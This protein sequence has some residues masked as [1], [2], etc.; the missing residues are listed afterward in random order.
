MALA[1]RDN[2][3]LK[4]KPMAV[5]G[6]SMLTTANYEARKFGVRSAVCS[7]RA[8]YVCTDSALVD[9]RIH[10]KEALSANH[11]CATK[12]QQISRCKQTNTS[13]LRQIRSAFCFG[14][15]R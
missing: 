7:T 15:I 11:S 10:S 2:P 1:E 14:L 3:K 12:L 4:G 5:G 6:D 13:H 9:A 8:C